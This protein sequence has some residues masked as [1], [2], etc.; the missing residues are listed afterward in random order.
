MS[1]GLNGVESLLE[2]EER[3]KEGFGIWFVA[4]DWLMLTR[5]LD[6]VTAQQMVGFIMGMGV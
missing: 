6:L 2:Y 3:K 1:A 5:V 4:M